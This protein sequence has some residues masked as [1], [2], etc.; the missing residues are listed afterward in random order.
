[1]KQVIKET[2]DW[3][4]EKDDEKREITIS[5]FEEFHYKDEITITYDEL[6]IAK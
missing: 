4:I 5:Y 3:V 6:N 2:D 1:M